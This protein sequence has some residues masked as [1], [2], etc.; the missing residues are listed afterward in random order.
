MA[1]M[2]ALEAARKAE[3]RRRHEMILAMRGSVWPGTRRRLRVG[4]FEHVEEALARGGVILWVAQCVS[5]DI[6]VK[7]AMFE[8]GYPLVQLSRPSHPFSDQ[9]FGQRFVNPLLRRAEDVFLAERV[10]IEGES[11]VAALRRLRA[12]LFEGRP[13]A[14]TVTPQAAAVVELSFLGGTLR[15][16]NGPVELAAATGSALI[17]V[18]VSGPP[19]GPK[20]EF[21]APLP[22][23][24]SAEDIRRAH[25][26]LAAWLRARIEADPLAW[27]GWRGFT[28]TRRPARE[29]ERQG[30]PAVAESP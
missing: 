20:V 2:S 3:V 15:L 16:A 14:I 4:G 6:A 1:G 17:P 27:A 11:A 19:A 26:S 9:P 13:I 22:A 5:S 18:F 30:P 29:R 7:Q 23:G 10:F 21:A 28:W 12:A 25:E 24:R 8:R